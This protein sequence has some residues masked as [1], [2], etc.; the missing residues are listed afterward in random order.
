MDMSA[1]TSWKR[2]HSNTLMSRSLAWAD[3]DCLEREREW[4]KLSPMC[5]MLRAIVSG[6]KLTNKPSKTLMQS[7][8]L[9]VLYSRAPIRTYPIKRWIKTQQSI[10]PETSTKQQT[11]LPIKGTS[12]CWVPKRHLLSCRSI[13]LA[14]LRLKITFWPNALTWIQ[15]CWDLVLS[16]ITNTVHGRRF[17]ALESTLLFTLGTNWSNQ[18]RSLVTGLTSCFQQDRCLSL[19]WLI[20]QSKA[21]W[22]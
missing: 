8:T 3:E 2:L 9:W 18:S 15:P 5:L 1:T 22:V 21:L 10:W 6:Q 16:L 20:S 14:K 7:F 11:G 4:R 17:L 19:Q 12:S 13:W